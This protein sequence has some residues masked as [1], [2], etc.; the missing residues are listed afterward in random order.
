MTPRFSQTV[1]QASGYV[2]AIVGL[3]WV[4]HDVKMDALVA[5]ARTMNLWWLAPAVLCD[6]VSYLCQ[7]IRWTYLLT[8]VGSLSPLRATQAIYVGL[9]AN[10]LLPMRFGEL[11]RAYLASRWM[12]ISTASVIPSMLVERLLDGV[13]VA[14]GIVATAMLVALPATV[15]RGIYIFG[16]VIGVAAL[17]FGFVLFR[18]P[19]RVADRA[20]SP[21]SGSRWRS[22]VDAFIRRITTDIRRISSPRILVAAAAFSAALLVFQAFAFWLVMVSYGLALPLGAGLAVFLLVHVGTAIPNAPANVGSFQFFTVLGLTLFGVE[23]SAAAAFSVTVFLVLTL[24][25]WALGSMALARSGTNLPALRLSIQ[26]VP[27]RAETVLN[28]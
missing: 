6:I 27:P 3:V 10:E 19:R 14:F 1:R 25:L 17:L 20:A 21:S 28:Q 7:G 12:R 4:F 23:K 16:A 15:L 11:V 8:P 13:W 2:L 5:S 22:L 26:E 18:G 9:F 24:P